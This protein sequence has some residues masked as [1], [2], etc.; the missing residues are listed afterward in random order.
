MTPINPAEP[1]RSQYAPGEITRVCDAAIT[2][3]DE[4]FL[5]IRAIPP[6]Q[7]TPDNTLLA[8][9]QALAEYN[10]RIMPLTFMGYVYPDPAI[11]SE[12]TACE[13]KAGMYSVSVFTRRDLYDAILAVTPRTPEE[14]RLHTETLRQFKKNG[15]ALPDDRLAKVRALKENLTRLEVR[16]SS[17]LNNDNTTLA[18]SAA[19]L[20]GVPAE[21][22]ATFQKAENGTFLVT[23][24]YP[25]YYAVMQN[26]KKSETRKAMQSAFLNRQAEENIR[27]L[28][29]AILVRQQIAREL[30]YATWA[31][32]R[33]DG[34]MAGSRE[35]VSAFL[36]G[37]KNPLKEK[38]RQELAELLAIKQ[39]LDPKAKSLDPWDLLY[40]NEQKRQQQYALDDESVRK[41]FPLDTV[42]KGMFDRFGPLFSVRFEEV[43]DANVWAPEVKL[44]RVI[45]ITKNRTVAYIY[46]DLFPRP[47]KYGHTMMVPLLSGRVADGQYTVPVAAIVGNFRAP[48][49][50]TPSLLT[51]DDVDGLFHEFGHTLHGCLTRAPYASLSGT[52]VEW[53]FV[54]TPSQAME[55]WAWQ[56]EVMN[57]ISGLYTNRSE[58]LPADIRD[59]IIAA[60]DMD[61]GQAYTRM[62]M[63]S[64]EDMEFHTA[65]GPV[66]VTGISDRMY[67]DLMGIPPVKGGHEPAVIGHFMGGYDAGYYSYL[68][69]KVY[70]LN[71]FERFR[72][73]GLGNTTT[74][75]AYRH[76][77]LEP[78]NMHDGK[79]LLSGFLGHEPGMDVFYER[80]HI[81]KDGTGTE[82]GPQSG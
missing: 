64:A 71:V 30:G 68:W 16:F 45:D 62:L 15:L 75:A 10:D 43:P 36:D 49:G 21:A 63:I 6:E 34:R 11:A 46:F 57:E 37:I 35:N 79:T 52:N 72:E 51:H 14:Q 55:E 77:I 29:E 61:I 48:N 81:R 2:S 82:N 44:Y 67:K 17:N 9:E 4:S 25:D 73:D 47:G 50:D 42:T 28:E 76:W 3:A 60:R 24:K 74:G 19:D 66:E 80:L 13:E 69:S 18:F 59:R 31:D 5:K 33:I 1:I 38:T 56:P 32:Y 65:Q 7:R 70:A 27:L 53:D 20:E 22:L 54:E 39:A 8:F 41:Y 26:A 23:T 78:G 12:G 58:K 40:L